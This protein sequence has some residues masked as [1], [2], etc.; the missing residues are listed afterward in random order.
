MAGRGFGKTRVGAE[1]VIDY[2]VEHPECRIA[3]I[4]PTLGDV[5]ATCFE[6]E[7]GLLACLPGSYRDSCYNRTLLELRI[8]GG[9]LIK[10]FSSQEP[11]RLRGPQHHF[12]WCEE[13]AAW[14]YAQ[15]TWDM[16]MFGLR[17]GDDPRTVITTTPKPVKLI[18]YLIANPHT[19]IT[20]GTSYENRDN[21]AP[22]FFD[23]II[24]KYE[25]TR[26]GRQELRAEVL[27]DV[28]GALWTR[29]RIDELRCS[30]M[31]ALLRVVVAIDPAMTC[32]EDSDETGLIAAGL[33]ANGHGYVL[34]DGSMRDTPTRW[35]TRAIE[36]LSE[37]RGDRIVGEVN[38]GG[39]LV[40]TTLRTISQNVPYRSVH[41][42]RG[43]VKRAEPVA[44]LYEQGKVHHVGSF[45]TLEDQM[46]AFTPEQVIKQSPDRADALVWALTELMIDGGL[47]QVAQQQDTWRTMPTISTF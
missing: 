45:E 17:L 25:G 41:A 34:S 18:R 40:E 21:L 4:A 32:N 8:P 10:G 19:H 6:G 15:D 46:C 28:P 1:N 27:D 31:P 26:L 22:A 23:E 16:L 43:K 20:R 44:A 47:R 9:S 7:S 33:G 30:T 13:A 38:N 5:R 2:A 24:R 39:D 42:S 29:V 37:H 3:V 12:A 36:M 35:A 14:I 11:D